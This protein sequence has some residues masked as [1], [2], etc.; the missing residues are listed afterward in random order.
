MGS[1]SD[2][3]GA[4]TT[5]PAPDPSVEPPPEELPSRGSVSNPLD[6]WGQGSPVE[7]SGVVTAVTAG[8]VC[9]G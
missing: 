4:P 2:V 1:V 9:R 3:S 8:L 7:V 5:G 6:R